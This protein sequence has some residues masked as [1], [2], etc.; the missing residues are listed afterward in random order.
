MNNLLIYLSGFIL[1]Y[2]YIRLWLWYIL[3][4]REW[5]TLSR[6]V[7][8]FFSLFSYVCLGVCLFISWALYQDDRDKDE[9]AKW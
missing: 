6:A 1:S 9:P 7:A 5:T 8:L 3:K 2:V 4:D